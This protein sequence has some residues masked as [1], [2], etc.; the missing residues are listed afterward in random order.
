MKRIMLLYVLAVFLLI[1]SL[2]IYA[3]SQYHLLGAWQVKPIPSNPADALNK[4]GPASTIDYINPGPQDCIKAGQA[5]YSDVSSCCAGLARIF[6]GYYSPVKSCEELSDISVAD[7]KVYY[8]CSAC[9]D[10][11][12][13]SWE[14]RCNCPKDCQF[15]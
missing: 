7:G 4:P 1:A 3:F 2:V 5:T 12:C 6:V 13:D 14:N 10:K 9:G 8:I 11:I 15:P